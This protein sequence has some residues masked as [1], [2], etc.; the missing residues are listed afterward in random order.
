MNIHILLNI[1]LILII[2]FLLVSMVKADYAD[3]KQL[4]E[5]YTQGFKDALKEKERH[6]NELLESVD[7]YHQGYVDHSYTR[8]RLAINS[9]M[10]YPSFLEK[11]QG[12]WV[13]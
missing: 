12:E 1:G 9:V 6:E 4:K 10:E 11:E 8:K 13:N 5:A 7:F 2:G 3:I